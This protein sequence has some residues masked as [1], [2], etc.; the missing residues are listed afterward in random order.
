MVDHVPDEEID[1]RLREEVPA[2]VPPA[3]FVDRVMLAHERDRTRLHIPPSRQKRLFSWLAASLAVAAAAV[4]TV[5]ILVPDMVWRPQSAAVSP[6][7]QLEPLAGPAAVASSDPDQGQ[8]VTTTGSDTTG[9][10]SAAR[11]APAGTDRRAEE[12]S[13]PPV[14]DLSPEDETVRPEPDRNAEAEEAGM[15]DACKA[16]ERNRRLNRAVTCYQEILEKKPDS[17]EAHLRLGA[18]YAKTNRIEPAY[19]EYR[20]FVELAPHHMMAPRVRLIMQ[21]YEEYKETN[22]IQDAHAHPVD[23]PPSGPTAAAPAE[24]NDAKA[25]ILYEQAYIDRNANPER[26]R[27]LLR[28]ALRLVPPGSL[29]H[30]RI[31]R[32]LARMHPHNQQGD[33]P[34]DEATVTRIIEKHQ[35]RILACLE[36]QRARNPEVTGTMRLAI[37]IEPGGDVYSIHL[38]TPE[39]R[40][41]FA[42]GCISFVIKQI[43]F[44]AFDGEPFFVTSIPFVLG[45]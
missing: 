25:K 27:N 38:E 42:F 4:I 1:L 22:I 34:I 21:R 17:P 30:R 7:L 26:A 5:W 40:N 12:R 13:V 28:Q 16:L 41:T 35:P 18:V 3:G 11:P 20:R 29:Y 39:H 15:L 2:G 31:M 37:T 32:L 43:K 36:K 24:R 45:G 33:K 19:R 23:P 8:D 14:V 6:T 9:S 10:V 44:P